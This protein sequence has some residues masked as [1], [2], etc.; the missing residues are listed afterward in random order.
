M[1]AN[2]LLVYC[3]TQPLPAGSGIQ[4]LSREWNKKEEMQVSKAKTSPKVVRVRVRV[5]DR[6]R[7]PYLQYYMYR[8]ACELHPC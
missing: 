6:V 2:G 3:Y 8:P 5:R 1:L 7:G 4:A